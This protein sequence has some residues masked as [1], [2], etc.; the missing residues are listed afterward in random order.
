MRR[1]LTLLLGVFALLP[2]FSQPF[3]RCHTYESLQ[4]FRALNPGAETDEHFENWLRQKIEDRSAQRMNAYYVVP[5][6]FHIVHN[7]EAAGTG[8]NVSA[9]QIQQQLNQLNADF[10][11]LSGSTYGVAADIEIQ[12]CLATVDELGTPLAEPGIDRINRNTEGWNAPPYDGFP[13]N[14]YVDMTIMPGS[15]WDPTKYYNIWT[16][17]L[18]GGLLGKATFPTSTTIPDIDVLPSN[19]NATHSG[20]F[21]DYR[22]VGSICTAGGFGTS[23]GLGR[24]LTHETGHYLGLRHIWGD[25]T[26]G[27]DFCN[28]TPV[29]RE[30]TSGC[31]SSVAS[32]YLQNCPNPGDGA[33]RMFENYMDYTDDACVNT[34]TADQKARMQAVMLNS[35]RRASLPGSGSCTGAAANSI[36]FNYVCAQASEAATGSTCPGFRDISVNILV[37]AA[38]SG[39][40]TLNFTKGGTATDNVDYMITPSTVTYNNGDNLPKTVAIRIWDDGL[41]ETSETLTLGYTITGTGV[42][43]G[44][45]NQTFSLTITDNDVATTI[46]NNGSITLFSQNFESGSIPGWQ[47]GSFIGTP[48]V[49][50][51]TLSANG[52]AG[53]TGISA[54]ITNDVTNRPLNY[55]NTST[56]DVILMTPFMSTTGAPNPTLSFK[57]KSEGEL[58]MGTYFDFGRLMYT[59]NGTNFFTITDGGGV[60]Y[61]FQGTPAATTATIPL[62]AALT[63]ATF[64]IGFR[65]TNDDVDGTPPPFLIDDV[66]VTT[67]AT[68]VESAASQPV[69]VNIFNNQDVYLKSSADGQVIARI[70]N[71]NANIGCLT[72]NVTQAGTGLIA[73][74]TNGGSFFRTEKVIQL[75]PATPNSSVLYTATFYFSTAELAA[76]GGSISTL[77]LMKVADGVNLASTLNTSNAQIITP[78]FSN[79][80]AS[81][82]YAFTGTFT[83]FSQFMLVSPNANLP[84]DL[85]TFEAKAI[86]KSILLSWSTAQEMNNKGFAIERSLTGNAN[87]FENIGW[88]DGKINSNSRSDY[89]YTDHFVQPGVTYYYRLRQTDMDNRYE[90]SITRQARIEEK[91]VA[92]TVTPNPASD[93][94]SLFISGATAK[95]EVTLLNMQGQLVR[96][97]SQVNASAAPYRLSINGLSSGVYMLQVQLPNEKLTEKLVIR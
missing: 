55:D 70:Q 44:S 48:G 59:L 90:F 4:H 31:P 7:G 3:T 57:Y 27:N 60:P 91:G 51:W 35:P 40:A 26:C 53:I 2:A 58:F 13:S 1:A 56:S 83:G 43:A 54:H 39:S 23:A 46:D 14:S 64:K 20:V 73:L 19:D 95:A 77:K 88:V 47:T 80:S 37:F 49:N 66:L 65:W 79:Q 67:D 12:F 16:M 84:V 45:G 38:A 78:I 50:V 18:S 87:D 75:T 81:G 22:S 10:A 21:I 15:I 42:V 36:K 71:A 93:H 17:D 33:K 85:I 6:I 30:N 69:T 11:N 97:W 9:A 8:S 68:R 76:W 94:V 72:A 5:V 34:F 62:P 63:N 92:L 25:A 89:N 29:Q 61:R 32:Q 41:V 82:Y 74:N 52:G 28:D 86:R 24:T 96:K